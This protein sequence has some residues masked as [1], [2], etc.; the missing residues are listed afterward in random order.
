MD[1]VN[2]GEVTEGE[3]YRLTVGAL[4][5]AAAA[6]NTEFGDFTLNASNSSAAK[7]ID[8]RYV[9]LTG[10][11]AITLNVGGANTTDAGD[12]YIDLI[13]N[14][15][16]GERFRAPIGMYASGEKQGAYYPDRS[17]RVRKSEK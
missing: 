13:E 6:A 10:A 3:T 4:D 12:V 16:N 1:I 5:T 15:E 7:A 8:G 9:A 2:S 17:V 11:D 14:D